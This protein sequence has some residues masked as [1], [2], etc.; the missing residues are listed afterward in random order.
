MA[1]DNQFLKKL[2]ILLVSV[3][4]CAGCNSKYPVEDA[5]RPLDATLAPTGILTPISTFKSIDSWLTYRNPAFRYEL[6]YP[7]QAMLSTEG[8]TGYPAEE[9]PSNMTPDEYLAKLTQIHPGDL[10]VRIEYQFGF[11]TTILSCNRL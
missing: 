2:L 7:P 5:N 6:S 8:V 3:L 11:I 4:V 1:K 9:L 10:C